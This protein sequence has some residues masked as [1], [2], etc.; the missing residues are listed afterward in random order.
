MHIII[1]MTRN[2]NTTRFLRVFV[3]SMTAYGTY[4][5]PTICFDHLDKITDLHL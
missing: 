2:S 1:W 5:I 3:L 4:A